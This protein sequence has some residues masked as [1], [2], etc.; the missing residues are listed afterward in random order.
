[1]ENIGSSEERAMSEINEICQAET[2]AILNDACSRMNCER[3]DIEFRI[4]KN[5]AIHVRR[6]KEN[7]IT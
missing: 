2:V 5:G 3:K 6:R 1:M 7:E 4:C